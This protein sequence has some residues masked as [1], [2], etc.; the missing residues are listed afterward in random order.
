MASQVNTNLFYQTKTNSSRV[1]QTAISN[2][3]IIKF[4]VEASYLPSAYKLPVSFKDSINN[5]P[6]YQRMTQRRNWFKG[7]VL[8]KLMGTIHY[9]LNVGYF[10]SENE[11]GELSKALLIVRGVF[12]NYKREHY[13]F[14]AEVKKKYE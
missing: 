5:E 3:Q 12:K 9:I 7:Y 11:H 14:K 10:L 6:N 2:K 1:V 8:T 4:D 13:K